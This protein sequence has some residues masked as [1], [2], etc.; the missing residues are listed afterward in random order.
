MNTLGWKS[1]VLQ[2]M[3]LIDSM[4]VDEICR[5]HNGV[6]AQFQTYAT[7]GFKTRLSS[8]DFASDWS[9]DLVRQWSIRG[10]VHAYLKEE[11]PLYLY[12]GRNY[13][14]PNLHQASWDGILSAEEKNYYAQ[15]ILHSLKSGNKKREDLK[16]ICREDGL[17]LEKEKTLFNAWG[18]IFFSLVAQGL[19][20]QE[21]GQRVFGLLEN[22]TPMA[23][24][25]A[26]LEIARRYFSGF[27]PVS[28]RDARYYFKEN[29]SVIETW[30]KKLDL[31]SIEVDG[32]T[33]FYSGELPDPVAIPKVL[34]IAGFDALLLS[35]EKRDNPFF[36]PRFIRNIYTMTG[37]LKPTIML[38]GQLV[39]T[40]RK[41]KGVTYIKPF[42]QMKVADKKIIL[43]TAEEKHPKIAFE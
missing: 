34:F 3:G 36:D 26:E 9:Q 21:Y 15:L 22:Y 14:K 1:I 16:M 29:K 38:D 19:I 28:L 13:C 37:I 5:Q 40:W 2:K 25:A 39:A 18:G 12:E 43:Q 41:E 23:K 35:L 10:T 30:M 31:T 17:S 7:E 8:E 11:I 24:E 27:G 6:Q 33:R 20:Y 42:S 4:T 32:K